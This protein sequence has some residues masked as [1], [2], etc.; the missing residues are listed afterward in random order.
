MALN[1]Y[2]SSDPG[3]H[4]KALAQLAGLAIAFLGNAVGVVLPFVEGLFFRTAVLP[5]LTAFLGN[6]INPMS[7]ESA[8]DLT[9][10]VLVIALCTMFALLLIPLPTAQV[11]KAGFFSL[12]IALFVT[13]LGFLIGLRP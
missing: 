10:A 7:L 6:L 8:L 4:I 11:F 3:A 9:Y 13:T 1:D 5:L 12:S 2:N